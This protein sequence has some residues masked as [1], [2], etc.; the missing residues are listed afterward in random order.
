MRRLSIALSAVAFHA[1]LQ[2]MILLG[3]TVPA[4][5]EAR[6]DRVQRTGLMRVCIWPDY[7]AISFRNP[8]SGELQGLDVDMA[9]AF[10]QDLGVRVS[11]VESGFSTVAADLLGDRC[12]IGMFGIGVTTERSERIAFSQPYL[13]SGIYAVSSQTHP[14]I[15]RWDDLD[16][17]G[18]V[19][20]VQKGTVMD[21][22]ASRSLRKASIRI[23]S[24]PQ[25]REEEV[26]SG[27]ADA[28]LTDYPY[29]R[30]VLTVHQWAHLITPDVPVQPTPYAYAVAPG[31]PV[32]LD[33]VNRFVEA[34]K[35]D[36]RLEA[37]AARFGLTPIVARD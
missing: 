3:G 1:A 5:A 34:V 27:R 10:G 21:D 33:R 7:Y 28:F 14:R 6:F 13:R 23:V 37:A 17:D 12:D 8:Y 18:M 36:G 9:R 32:W 30:R 22:Y 2:S 20:A 31:D 19:V 24:G 15:L 16:Q 11:F 35:R 29:G 4:R 26:Q 25:E